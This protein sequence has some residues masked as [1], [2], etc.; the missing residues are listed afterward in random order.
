MRF[1]VLRRSGSDRHLDYYAD[2]ASSQAGGQ[3]SGT[4]DLQV[5]FVRAFAVVVH[6]HCHCSRASPPLSSFH[7]YSPKPVRVQ[8]IAIVKPDSFFDPRGGRGYI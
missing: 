3:P 8:R 5:C 6:M 7:L 1:F 2:E 4:L